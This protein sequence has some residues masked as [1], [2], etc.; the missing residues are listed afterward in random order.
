MRQKHVA[1]VGK[2]GVGNARL[3]AAV[4]EFADFALVAAIE[5]DLRAAIQSVAVS[6]GMI[7][8][9]VDALEKGRRI[10]VS[11]LSGKL[12]GWH[13]EIAPH[14]GIHDQMIVALVIRKGGIGILG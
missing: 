3:L 7:G 4:L 13:F 10:C 2:Q 5:G 12:S 1:F 9:L 14:D 11:S 6:S 8:I